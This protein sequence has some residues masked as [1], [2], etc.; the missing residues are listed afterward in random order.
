MI[1]K[2]R[3]LWDCGYKIAP[4]KHAVLLKELAKAD[5]I[6]SSK[7]WWKISLLYKMHI[8]NVI[9]KINVRRLSGGFLYN[10]AIT[11]SN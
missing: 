11:F 3:S 6:D 5:F 8:S 1:I 2:S 10:I 4:A 7:N 9:S